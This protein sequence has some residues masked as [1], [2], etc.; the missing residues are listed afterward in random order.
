[1][2]NQTIKQILKKKGVSHLYHA[3]TMITACTF[4]EN[5]GLLSRGAVED[6]GLSQSPQI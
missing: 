6:L 4:I 2:T 5:G 1:M 3:N